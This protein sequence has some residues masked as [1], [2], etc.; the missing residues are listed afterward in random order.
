MKIEILPGGKGNNETK[1]TT[2][3]QGWTAPS[4]YISG[5]I[6]HKTLALKSLIQRDMSVEFIDQANRICDALLADAD[7]VAC[8]E[9]APLEGGC[10]G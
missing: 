10:H 3:N 1:R 8:L 4:G 2:G 6:V 7:T 5:K 9:T